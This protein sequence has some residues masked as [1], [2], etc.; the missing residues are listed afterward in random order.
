MSKSIKI[1]VLEVGDFLT[2]CYLV[3]N[4]DQAIVIDPGDGPDKILALI[5]SRRV[6]VEKIILTHGHIDHIGAVPEIKKATKAP[7]LIHHKDANML[8]DAKAN[9]S[10]YHSEA[11]SFEPADA[12]LNE[13]DIVKIGDAQLRV[14]G[15]PGHTPGGISLLGDGV[16]FTGDALFFG[17]VGRTDLMGGN[18]EQLL[19]SIKDKLLILPDDTQVFPGHGPQTTIGNERF[20]NPWLT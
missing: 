11:F 20:A 19:K 6:T 15:T 7:V 2:N 8:T 10:Y 14:L 3:H 12:F 18:H 17:S 9:L 5:D 16:V 13:N 1:D 4:N